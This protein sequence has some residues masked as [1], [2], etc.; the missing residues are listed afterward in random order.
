MILSDAKV[1]S[2][3]KFEVKLHRHR[4]EQYRK[5]SGWNSQ[6]KLR[7]VLE[8]AS[9]DRAYD[10][11]GILPYAGQRAV[12]KLRVTSRSAQAA[13]GGIAGKLYIMGGISNGGAVQLGGDRFDFVH[14]RWET[15]PRPNVPRCFSP[16]A[17]LGGELYFCGTTE[18]GS[19]SV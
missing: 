14:G 6:A 15:V 8:G 12:Q 7:D 16:G 19:R 10:A 18:I 9:G 1:F 13:P 5:A 11:F 3:Q 2:G 4:F 17:L